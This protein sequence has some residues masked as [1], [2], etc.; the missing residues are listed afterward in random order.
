MG[1]RTFSGSDIKRAIVEFQNS[2]IDKTESTHNEI[3]GFAPKINAVIIKAD[4]IKEAPDEL[5]DFAHKDNLP[6]I[7][8]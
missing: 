8:I 5:L 4:N 6:V 7:L 1:K 3:I 2:L